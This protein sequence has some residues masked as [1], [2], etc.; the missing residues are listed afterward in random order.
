MT[1]TNQRTINPA[2]RSIESADPDARW[3]KKGSRYFFGY[4]GFVTVEEKHGF[5]RG[6]HVTPANR[7]EV[8]ELE[9][10]VRNAGTV[11]GLYADKGYASKANRAWLNEQGI[12][13]GIMYNGSAA[14]PLDAIEK[15][16]NRIISQVRWKVEQCFGTLK[17][18][19]GFS[20]SR[21]RTVERVESEL[22]WKSICFNLLKAQ[23]LLR[24]KCA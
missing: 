11:K 9:N 23:R 15:L 17:R 18:R 6:L 22:Y 13:D 1:A 24:D 16:T 2:L 20:R 4:K 8:K 12:T 19:F 10:A 7:A 14:K 3:L 5:I 21:Y